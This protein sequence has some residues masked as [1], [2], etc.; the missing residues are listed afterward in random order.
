MFIIDLDNTLMDTA[1]DFKN[2]RVAD[3]ESLGITR[4]LYE[5][6]YSLAR[7]GQ[8]GKA[9]YSNAR[10]AK[11]LSYEGFDE[12][13][14]L[15][16]L[17][18]TLVPQEIKKYLYSDAISFLENL[19][20]F[21]M[22][23]ILLTLGNPAFQEEKIKALEIERYFDRVILTNEKK[24]IK[25]E[26]IL[27]SLTDR[28]AWFINDRILENVEVSKME[29]A[30]VVQ[31]QYQFVEEF[32]YKETDLPYFKTLTEIYDYISKSFK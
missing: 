30:K 11:V 16:L 27:E 20:K 12:S 28:P 4:E 9:V 1:G 24:T 13:Q 19:K 32:E 22:P 6:T 21:K 18:K 29:G 26:Q 31:K 14:V 17:N 10:H 7:N 3:L 23:L 2:A 15:N 25:V 5:K 8:E